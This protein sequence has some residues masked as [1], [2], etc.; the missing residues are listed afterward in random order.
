MRLFVAIELSQAVRAHLLRVHDLLRPI[1]G[2]DVSFTRPQN[3]HVTLKFF[4]EATE[5]QLPHLCK[6]IE[7]V[8]RPD[9][10][11][12]A[13]AQ[14][15]CLPPGGP[16]RIIAAGPQLIPPELLSLH[17]QIE[18]A[19]APHGFP[20]E[21]RPYRPHVTLARARRPLR[22]SLRAQLA[23]ATQP[24]WPTPIMPV[25]EIVLMQSRL[26]QAGPQ[27]TPLARLKF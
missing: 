26:S 19:C 5:Q 8:P 12:F 1:A 13:F 2:D 11:D 25:D 9:A 21:N 17:A 15:A 22:S 4:G 14:M 7:A 18:H 3:L 16:I 20:T 27:Y 6:S 23:S 24:L 10:F